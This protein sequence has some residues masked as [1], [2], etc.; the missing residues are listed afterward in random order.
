VTA[1]SGAADTGRDPASLPDAPPPQLL[2]APTHDGND[3]NGRADPVLVRDMVVR[4]GLGEAGVGENG[5]AARD[6]DARPAM[7]LDRASALAGA[8]Y[9]TVSR[10]VLGT[11][12]AVTVT[13]VAA[14]SCGHLLIEDVPGTGKTVLGR[15]LA[16][17]LGAELSRIQGHTDLLPSDVTGVSVYAPDRGDWRFHPGPVFAH[18]VLLDELN[19]TPPRTQSALLEA[20]GEEQV[21][22][23]GTR[24]PLPSPHLVI[25][26]QNPVG[27]L[28]TFPLVESQLDRFALSTPLGYP[29]DATE[30]R[31]AMGEGGRPELSRVHAVCGT[32]EWAALVDACAR[33]RVSPP[34][35]QYAVRLTR[36]TRDSSAVRL[37]ASPRASITLVRSAQAHALLEGRE[38]VAP[39]DVQAMAVP[40]LAHR[41]VGDG[42]LD[43]R[44]AVVRDVLRSVPAPRP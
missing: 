6:P 35:A 36:A 43:E 3:G 12:G 29:D 17:A 19:R 30:F 9:D 25:A 42:T 34:V 39:I 4:R 32:A 15:T 38:F 44:A 22:V 8:L 16:S 10:V 23:D 2:D 20:M 27:Q 37:G 5:P 13:V 24:W 33:V 11:P 26:T 41:L 18:V 1:W 40:G 14:V 28:G 21:T 31:L 7:S